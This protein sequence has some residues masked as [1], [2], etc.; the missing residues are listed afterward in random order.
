MRCRPRRTTTQACR[1]ARLSFR[2]IS[3]AR[4]AFFE[5][6]LILLHSFTAYICN[7]NNG[8]DPGPCLHASRKNGLSNTLYNRDSRISPCS[9]RA[10]RATRRSSTT[11]VQVKHEVRV[12]PPCCAPASAPAALG[13]L[14]GWPRAASAPCAACGQRGAPGRGA[15]CTAHG[16]HVHGHVHVVMREG[17]APGPGPRFSFNF[18]RIWDSFWSPGRPLGL[19]VPPLCFSSPF[20]APSLRRFLATSVADLIFL[21]FGVPIGEK[22]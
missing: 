5:G 11:L 7:G 8:Q 9:H 14:R 4:L 15:H 22:K 21:H 1:R 19:H 12:R 20:F 10:S 16:T 2:H 3:L 18:K 17:W 13:W 6:E